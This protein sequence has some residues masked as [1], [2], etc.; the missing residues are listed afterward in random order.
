M[1]ELPLYKE[2]WDK[3][4]YHKRLKICFVFNELGKCDNCHFEIAKGDCPRDI[5]EFLLCLSKSII[6]S[7]IKIPNKFT[8][9]DE[10]EINSQHALQT[11]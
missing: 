3:T 7:F 1:R 8:L 4:F 5:K 6:G 2:L 10:I 9:S 11:G